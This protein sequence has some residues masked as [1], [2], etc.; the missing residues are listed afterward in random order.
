MQPEISLLLKTA[1]KSVVR[2]VIEV[3]KGDRKKIGS[4]VMKRDLTIS[5]YLFCVFEFV[6]YGSEK[7]MRFFFGDDEEFFISFQRKMCN[8]IEMTQAIEKVASNKH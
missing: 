7:R 4:E 3:T 2:Q 8:E 5:L 1:K 6:P